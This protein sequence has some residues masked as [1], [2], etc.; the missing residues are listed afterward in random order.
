MAEPKWFMTLS[1]EV[2]LRKMLKN[3]PK[4]GLKGFLKVLK[5]FYPCNNGITIPLIAVG[6]LKS[7][8][9]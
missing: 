1:K 6:R 8:I 2:I 5:T 4:T 3:S 7:Y 9:G